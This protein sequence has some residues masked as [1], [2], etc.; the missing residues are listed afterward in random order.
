MITQVNGI[1]YLN[2]FQLTLACPLVVAPGQQFTCTIQVSFNLPNGQ[3]I[4]DPFGIAV[5]PQYESD[6]Y[7]T[8]SVEIPVP[9][10]T[11]SSYGYDSSVLTGTFNYTYDSTRSSRTVYVYPFDYSSSYAL[12]TIYV[13]RSKKNL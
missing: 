13:T 9:L 3:R 10:T 12:Q 11:S 6:Y 5:Y 8:L 1:T 4:L 7:S 2:F